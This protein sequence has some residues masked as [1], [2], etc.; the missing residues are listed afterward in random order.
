MR[1]TILISTTLAVA[2]LLGGVAV[3]GAAPTG[4]PDGAKGRTLHFDVRFSPFHL[5]DVG[6]DGAPNL[7]DYVVFHDVLLVDG[8]QVGDEGGS[9]PLVDVEQQVIHCTGT[10]RLADGQITFQGL[11]TTAATKHLAVTGGTGR[12]QG[13]AGEATLVEFPDQ[14]GT[15]TVRLR[16]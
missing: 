7:G 10:I 12:Y 2:L 11:T 1:R 13:V 9:C 16:R 6:G 15:L 8:R 4:K 5:V 3:A 14:T